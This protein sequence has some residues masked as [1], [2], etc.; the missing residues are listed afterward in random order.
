MTQYTEDIQDQLG[1][2][3]VVWQGLHNL[4]EN[5]ALADGIPF[6]NGPYY[7]PI[8]KAAYDSSA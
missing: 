8:S 6:T 3:Q 2:E 7:Y 5:H 1:Q 4:S